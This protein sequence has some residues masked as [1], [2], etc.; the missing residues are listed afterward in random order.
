M[1]PGRPAK[2][3]EGRSGGRVLLRILGGFSIITA[4][5]WASLKIMDSWVQPPNAAEIRVSEATYGANC[6]DFKPSEG[7]E[8]KV[9]KGNATQA[10]KENCAGAKSAC[11][12]TV[13]TGLLGDPAPGCQ[14]DFIVRW[15]CGDI[16]RVHQLYILEEAH[17]K[18]A[19]L[20]CP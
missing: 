14:K 15:R 17:T 8:N 7:R 16:E 6:R 3:G 5:F 2:Y 18:N 19:P 9:A 20:T 10:V 13:D 11:T 12:F 1:R 4:S